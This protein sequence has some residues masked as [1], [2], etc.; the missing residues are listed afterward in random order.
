VQAVMFARME[1]DER[2]T[3]PP[4]ELELHPSNVVAAMERFPVAVEL[5]RAHSEDERAR[6]RVSIQG[7]GLACR[8]Y[9]S[10][11]DLIGIQQQLFDSFMN[12]N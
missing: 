9:R 1:L 8:R 3:A 2:E 11:K 6:N 7:I 10:A 12:E 4:L 5:Y